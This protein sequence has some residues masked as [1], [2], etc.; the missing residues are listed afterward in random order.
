MTSQQFRT[1]ADLPDGTLDE[2]AAVLKMLGHADRIR[3]IGLLIEKSRSVGD[4]AQAAGLAPNAASQHLGLME[5]RGIVERSR[6]GRNVYYTVSHRIARNLMRCLLG[7]RDE[8]DG[9]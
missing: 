3:I 4:V 5:S 1:L 6:R 9:S 8:T 2:T 7:P